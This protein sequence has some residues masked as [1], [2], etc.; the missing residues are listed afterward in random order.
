MKNTGKDFRIGQRRCLKVKN[1]NKIVDTAQK[2]GKEWQM[3]QT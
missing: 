2:G 3:E 1:E